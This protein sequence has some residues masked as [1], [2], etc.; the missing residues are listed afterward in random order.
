MKLST[1]RLL[2]ANSADPNITNNR[3][4]TAINIAEYL[5]PDQK[6]DFINVLIRTY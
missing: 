6:Q 1:V 4:E 5:Q 3:G 2:I